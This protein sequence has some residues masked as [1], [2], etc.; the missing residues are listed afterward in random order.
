MKIDTQITVRLALFAAISIVLGKFLQIPIGESIRISF[1]NLTLIL[2]GY[3]YGP[4]A[5]VLCAVCADL[6][7]CILR[8]YAIN[9]IIMAGAAVI[10]LFAGAFGRKG[11][12]KKPSLA[13]SVA[14]AHVCGSMIIK[15]IGLKVYFATP[16]IELLPRIPIYIV[17]GSIEYLLIRF[18]LN[19][20]G[21][22]EL[23]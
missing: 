4:L 22:K 10:G 19:H 23:L 3:L 12:F 15:S 9:P 18:C 8:A 14:F 6:L 7:G 2:A 16:W 13:L 11:F 5:G 1:E 20:K 17:V 21:F